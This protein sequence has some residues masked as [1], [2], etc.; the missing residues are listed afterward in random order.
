MWSDCFSISL[1]ITR[2]WTLLRTVR[3]TMIR[4]FTRVFGWCNSMYFV[5]NFYSYSLH[6]TLDF[7][8]MCF[9]YHLKLYRNRRGLRVM[10]NYI[11]R[12][13]AN[14]LLNCYL[15]SCF[16]AQLFRWWWENSMIPSYVWT[17][18]CTHQKRSH[19]L[20]STQLTIP[21]QIIPHGQRA[22]KYFVLQ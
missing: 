16:R 6:Y 13:K 3:V 5:L 8:W 17:V 20:F 21:P 22:R 2:S 14:I 9:E 12:H 1:A 7:V 19:Q 10:F 18:R 15:V 4:Y 11:H